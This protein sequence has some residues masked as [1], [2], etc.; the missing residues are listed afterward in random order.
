MK[1]TKISSDY[2]NLLPRDL[3]KEREMKQKEQLKYILNNNNLPESGRRK[4]EI[5]R[6]LEFS[7]R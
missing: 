7:K 6:E 1:N 2:P 4:R 3:A 5:C